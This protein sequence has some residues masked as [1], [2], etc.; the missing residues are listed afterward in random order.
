MREDLLLEIFGEE[1]EEA[2][3]GAE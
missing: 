1:D 3:I 2:L